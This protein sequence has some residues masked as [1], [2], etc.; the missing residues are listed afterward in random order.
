[1]PHLVTRVRRHVG[2]YSHPRNRIALSGDDVGAVDGRGVRIAL[3][4]RRPAAICRR[5]WRDNPRTDPPIQQ[6]F[7]LVE[8]GGAKRAADKEHRIAGA[9]DP[10]DPRGRARLVEHSHGHRLRFDEERRIAAKW[11]EARKLTAVRATCRG[12]AVGQHRRSRKVAVEEKQLSSGEI[13]HDH[14]A[15]GQRAYG[16]DGTQHAG[17]RDVPDS[18]NRADWRP[19][20]DESALHTTHRDGKRSG[21]SAQGADCVR[22]ATK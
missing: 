3:Q 19:L 20:R 11:Y 10:H 21:W 8:A 1:M 14:P 7:T 13:V 4:E 16:G 12:G 18:P 9:W 2:R 5:W 17:R 6:P 22:D 15:I